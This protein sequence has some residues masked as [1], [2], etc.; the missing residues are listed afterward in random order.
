MGQ[1]NRVIAINTGTGFVECITNV[2]LNINKDSIKSVSSINKR[3]LKKLWLIQTDLDVENVRVFCPVTKEHITAVRNISL[4]MNLPLSCYIPNNRLCPPLL[5]NNQENVL[6]AFT[7]TPQASGG[8]QYKFHHKLDSSGGMLF[9]YTTSNHTLQ[10]WSPGTILFR[11]TPVIQFF[12]CIKHRKKKGKCYTLFVQRPHNKSVWLNDRELTPV[13]QPL[14]QLVLVRLYAFL[15]LNR[16]WTTYR[17][18]YRRWYV[19]GIITTYCEAHMNK[20]EKRLWEAK[21]NTSCDSMQ[22]WCSLAIFCGPQLSKARAWDL[23]LRRTLSELAV[24][25]YSTG[26]VFLNAPDDHKHYWGH[27]LSN[28]HTVCEAVWS[29]LF[30][31]KGIRE[32]NRLSNISNSITTTPQHSFRIV[33]AMGN[34]NRATKQN[35]EFEISSKE[36]HLKVQAVLPPILLSHT[37]CKLPDSDRLHLCNNCLIPL[38]SDSLTCR[39]CN[40]VFYCNWRCKRADLGKHSMWCRSCNVISNIL[41]EV[42]TR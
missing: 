12:K 6:V 20:L 27:Q 32:L 38:I 18:E 24:V 7:I 16:Y 19:K 17:Y 42:H 1:Q 23:V 41:P 2:F 29:G 31:V 10:C 9:P 34:D 21:Y 30:G 35:V 14:K 8:V 22:V 13:K 33:V 4:N 37:P 3:V 40:V 25:Q 11:K 39:Q 36:K 5:H 26:I 15:L 28:I